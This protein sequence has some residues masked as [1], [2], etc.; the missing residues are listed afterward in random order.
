MSLRSFVAAALSA[1]LWPAAGAASPPGEATSAADTREAQMPSP[2]GA[3]GAKVLLVDRPDL[4]LSL[5]GFGQFYAA[6]LAGNDAL[7]AA[8]DASE[9]AG[10]RVRRLQLG[11]EGRGTSDVSFGIWMDLASSPSLVQAWLAWSPSRAFAVE[12]GVVR[13]P[14]SRSA[15]QSSADMTFSERP[16]A[17]DRLLPD[18]Q[19]G[20][21]VY[22]S[23]SDV[24][25]YRAGWFNGADPSRMGIGPDHTA[26]LLAGRIAFTPFGLLRPSQSDVARGP[27]KLEIAVDAMHHEAAAF[28]GT[29]L[30]AD[31][32]VQAYGTS[33]LLEYV[34]DRR[35]PL[36]QPV[37]AATLT[38][39]VER[40]GLIAQAAVQIAGP[41]ELAVRGELVDD[42]AA[43]QD[44]GDVLA[45]AAGVHAT[46]PQAKVGLD[47]YHRMERYGPELSNDVALA[48]VQGRF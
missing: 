39:A 31:L 45:T 21:A 35:A 1:G 42:N 34:E 29:T 36:P 12:A 40:T 20:V 14:F 48:T 28:R 11:V 32:T 4:Q 13:V 8:G 47:W 41:F 6:P 38:D 9:F 7:V 5:R 33:L 30:G 15:L 26:G 16:L 46:W 43:L 24:L 23:L 10:M 17:V 2:G 27:L 44:V 19:P 3:S 25:S 18:R 37:V 22:G